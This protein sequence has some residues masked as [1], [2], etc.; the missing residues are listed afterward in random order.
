MR[1]LTVLMALCTVLGCG[2]DD[3]E[4]ALLGVYTI[5]SW[6]A[7]EAGCGSPGDSILEMQSSTHFNFKQVDFFGVNVLTLGLCADLAECEADF[8]DTDSIDIGY[9]FE[10]GSDANGWTGYI[11]FGSTDGNDNCIATV[12]EHL[13]IGE[14]VDGVRV[15]TETRTTDMAPQEADGSCDLE[16]ARDMVMDQ[17]CEETESFAGSLVP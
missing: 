1:K 14:G 10:G 8:A 15:T 5:D 17:P 4:S 6:T 7:N 11:S 13:L 12:R 16:A 3:D 2:G 9:A